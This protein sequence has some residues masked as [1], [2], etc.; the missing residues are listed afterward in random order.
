[1][2]DPPLVFAAVTLDGLEVAEYKGA[3]PP[4]GAGFHRYA[5]LIF[6][7][8]RPLQGS[9]KEMAKGALNAAREAFN[10][11]VFSAINGLDAK[12]FRYFTAQ[13]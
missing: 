3:T 8:S 7:Q 5:V 13:S 2:T 11:S 6:E 9:S 4:N 10:L 1:M 12:G